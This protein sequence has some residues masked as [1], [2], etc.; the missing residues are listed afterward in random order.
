MMNLNLNVNKVH[1]KDVKIGT[2]ITSLLKK[3]KA[4]E[5]AK[6]QFRIERL[7]FLVGVIHNLQEWC[8]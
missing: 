6:I 2:V 8:P 5:G 7:D 3:L 1:Y 4:S